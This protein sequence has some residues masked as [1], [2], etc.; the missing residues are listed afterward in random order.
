MLSGVEG[1]LPALAATYLT[2][3]SLDAAFRQ[4]TLECMSRRSDEIHREARS[5]EAATRNRATRK[6]SRLEMRQKGCGAKAI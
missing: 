4:A 5:G 6:V 3:R 2:G 1:P